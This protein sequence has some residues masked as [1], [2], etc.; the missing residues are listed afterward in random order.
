MEL[1]SLEDDSESSEAMERSCSAIVVDM[2]Q[3]DF[4]FCLISPMAENDSLL[5]VQCS[6]EQDAQSLGNISGLIEEDGHCTKNRLVGLAATCAMVAFPPLCCFL[7]L[8]FVL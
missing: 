8:I 2:E 3:D 6:E 7:S 1:C 5:F 4:R